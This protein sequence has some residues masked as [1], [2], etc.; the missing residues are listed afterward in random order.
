MMTEPH[1][2]G[3]CVPAQFVA[4]LNNEHA[5]MSFHSV[6]LGVLNLICGC[7]IRAPLPIVCTVFL[8]KCIE[9]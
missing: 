8:N 6:V 3:V 7:G 4:L 1:I 5:C 9:A 2:G